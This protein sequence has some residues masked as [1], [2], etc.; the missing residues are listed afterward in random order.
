MTSISKFSWFDYPNI[1]YSFLLVFIPDPLRIVVVFHFNF[2]N[3][4][5]SLLVKLVK[6][7]KFRHVLDPLN[8]KSDWMEV[9]NI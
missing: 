6:F 7:L 8:M 9:K 2:M 1:S 4:F 3:L 5:L